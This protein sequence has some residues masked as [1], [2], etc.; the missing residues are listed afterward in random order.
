MVE[1]T[2]QHDLAFAR[3]HEALA[4]LREPDSTAALIEQ[5]AAATCVLGFDRAILPR[6]EDSGGP[7]PAPRAPEPP[8]FVAQVPSYGDYLPTGG[9][10]RGLTRREIEVLRLMAVSDTNSRIA[11]RLVISEGTVKSHV[12]HILRKLRAANRA[13]AVSRWLRMECERAGS[14]SAGLGM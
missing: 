5:A 13:E 9:D 14:W 12:K 3:M 1:R 6:I 10:N 4:V 8:G 2:R 11:R 7:A